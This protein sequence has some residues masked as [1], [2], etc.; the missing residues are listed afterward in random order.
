[1]MRDDTAA[2]SDYSNVNPDST[3]GTHITTSYLATGSSA[4]ESHFIKDTR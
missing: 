1:M 2:G 4:F 3:A